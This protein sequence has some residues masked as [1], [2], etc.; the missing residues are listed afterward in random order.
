MNYHNYETAI[1]ETYGV[2]LVGWPHRVNFI[3]PL[4][5]GTVGNIRKLQDALKSCICYWTVLSPAE[6]KSHAA[7]LN[8]HHL[9]GEI[10]CKPCK[11]CL[12]SEVPQKR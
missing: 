11:K 12:D 3:S 9:A 10:V 2:H 4:N 5:I 8:M 1:I 6:V 7:E